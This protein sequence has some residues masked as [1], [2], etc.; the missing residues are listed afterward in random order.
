MYRYRRISEARAA[1]REIG[2]RGAMFPWQSGSDGDEETQRV[3]LNPLSGRWEP[4]LSRNQRHVNAAIF[5]NVWCYYHATHDLEFLRDHGAEMLLEIAR[6]WSSHRPLQPG[7]RPVGDPWGHGPR[8]VPREASGRDRGR[9]AQQRLHE[10]HGGVDLRDGADGARP[11]PREPPRCPAGE[12]RARRRRDAQVGAD[13]PQDVRALPRRR[14]HQP[15]RGLRAA[16]RARLGR[17]PRAL[18]HHPATRPDPAGGGRR[19]QPLQDRQAGRRGDAVLPVLRGPAAAALRTARLRVRTR[20]RAQD[21]RLLRPADLARVDPELRRPR[22]RPRSHRSRKLVGA[23]P[24]RAGERRRRRPAGDDAGGC[25]HGRDVRDARPHPAGLPRRRRP[26][27]CRVLRS[28]AHRPARRAV[29]SDAVPP[30]PDQGDGAATASSPSRLSP[31]G[32]ARASGSASA[33]TSGRWARTSAACSRLGARPSRTARRETAQRARAL[34]RRDPRRGRRAR[35]H[36]A[37]AGVAGHARGADGHAVERHPRRDELL[38]AAL[39]VGRLPGVDRRQATHERSPRRA[40]P[41]PRAGRG[42]AR[43]GLRPAQ[44]ADG[45]RAHRGRRLRRVRRRAAL[46]RRAEGCRDPAGGSVVIQERRAGAPAGPSR[47]GPLPARRARRGR[48][49]P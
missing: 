32:S 43:R 48:L 25:S 49:G 4:D 38:A 6:F 23:V 18:R 15:V 40:R 45:R 37:R 12:D 2:C 13:E 47:T 24:G 30:H 7:A 3:H 46:R 21:D 16:G 42:K 33:R 19:P 36:S 10:R 20:H 39:H 14:R 34:S 26:R 1:A 28:E 35:R 31:T 17:L 44:A 8:R 22:R 9:P 27:R 29:A 11:A 41:L 5:Y